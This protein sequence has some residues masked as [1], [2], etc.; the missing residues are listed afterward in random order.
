MLTRQSVL[1]AIDEVPFEQLEQIFQVAISLKPKKKA[2]IAAKKKY[3]SFAGL[4]S[5]FSKKNFIT[6][7]KKTRKHLFQRDVNL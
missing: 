3:L 5:D 6:E 7:M 4:L 2:T 1:K